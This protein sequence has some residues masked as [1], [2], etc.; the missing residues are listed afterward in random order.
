MAE[1]GLVQRSPRVA[2]AW[3][4]SSRVS[5]RRFVLRPFARRTYPAS[6]EPASSDI[7]GG[8]RYAASREGDNINGNRYEKLIAPRLSVGRARDYA[9]K[10]VC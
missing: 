4:R 8:S 5:A 6:D 3:R 1:P 7:M 10:V 9:Q 2:R